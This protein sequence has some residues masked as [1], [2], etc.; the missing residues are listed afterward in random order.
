MDEEVKEALLTIANDIF[1][2][3]IDKQEG[4]VFEW[5]D[6]L[7]PFTEPI[8]SWVDSDGDKQHRVLLT[9]ENETSKDITRA[10]Y[11]LGETDE[12]TF[13]DQEDA[14]GEIANVIGGNMKSIFEDS[15]SLSIPR[16]S[17]SKP[18]DEETP[19][20]SVNL[21]WKGKF[22]VISISDL[23]VADAA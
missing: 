22:L 1:Y 13:E 20:L 21:N 5:F 3:L 17:M 6:E 9:M 18:T 12:V 4:T 10:M 23:D 16:V 19:I 14:F 11:L 7:E 8:Y 2:A 15:G